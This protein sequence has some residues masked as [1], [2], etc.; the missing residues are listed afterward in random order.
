MSRRLALSAGA[1]VAVVAAASA[2]AAPSQPAR[3]QVTATEFSF[4]LS[5]S[6][7]PAGAAV[8]GLVNMGEDDH[9]LRLRRRAPGARTWAVRTVAP[10]AFRERT[11]RLVRGRYQLWCTIADHRARG[12]RATLSVRARPAS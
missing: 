11:L 3:L 10:G 5:R 12:M 6:A 7:V 4:V 1:V 2:A 8:V 9:D